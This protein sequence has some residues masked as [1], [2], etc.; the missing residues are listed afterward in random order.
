MT[1]DERRQYMLNRL[2][3]GE[4]LKS[5]QLADELNVSE[6]TVRRDVDA[7]TCE[8]PVEAVRGRYGGG[9]KMADWFRPSRKVLTKEQIAAIRKAAQFLDG[10]D[11]Q[12]LMSVISQFS[13][14]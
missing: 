13:G 1:A 6:R 12:A 4:V 10:E 14:S 8:Y 7:I 2:F 9:I 3:S 11:R 5:E